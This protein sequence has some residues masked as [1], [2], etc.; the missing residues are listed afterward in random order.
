[1]TVGK[2]DLK[3]KISLLNR[4][5]H[6]DGFILKEKRIPLVITIVNRKSL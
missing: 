1:M 6:R 3:Q 5:Y 2:T 4:V